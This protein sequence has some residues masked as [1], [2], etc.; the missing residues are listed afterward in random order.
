M[1]NRIDYWRARQGQTYRSIAERAGT[2]AQY[3]WMLAKGRRSN[4]GLATMRKIA[5][6]LGKT[7]TQVFPLEG[8][9]V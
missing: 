7:I 1:K 9:G 3:V 4:P 2:T 5:A 8:K 6:A